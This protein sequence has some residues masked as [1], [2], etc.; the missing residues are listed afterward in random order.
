MRK[1]FQKSRS[2]CIKIQSSKRAQN[3]R[4]SWDG[5][6][7]EAEGIGRRWW[8][9][10]Q[11]LEVNGSLEPENQ[12]PVVVGRGV[13]GDGRRERSC[14]IMIEGQWESHSNSL[15]DRWWEGRKG[16]RLW[17]NFCRT[18]KLRW[19]TA[20]AGKMAVIEDDSQPCVNSDTFN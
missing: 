14:R 5:E 4:K 17:R 19:L 1:G 8:L 11:Q 3:F 2:A 6:W 18:V 9:I 12:W 15:T 10:L 13:R 16:N 20:C 7:L